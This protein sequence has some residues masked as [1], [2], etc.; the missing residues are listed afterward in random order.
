MSVAAA[1]LGVMP[2]KIATPK[3]AIKI[4]ADFIE[5]KNVLAG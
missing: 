1:A 5:T 2:A 4:I 3:T